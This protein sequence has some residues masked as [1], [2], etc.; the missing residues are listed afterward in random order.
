MSCG[1]GNDVTSSGASAVSAAAPASNASPAITQSTPATTATEPKVNGQI[2][3]RTGVAPV[4][5]QMTFVNPELLEI[6]N[7]SATF[8]GTGP[9]LNI[10]S[11]P[12]FG[13]CYALMPYIAFGNPWTVYS[14][15]G[16]VSS[17]TYGEPTPH[18]KSASERYS[19]QKLSST[20]KATCDR[21]RMQSTLSESAWNNCIALGGVPAGPFCMSYDEFKSY[22]GS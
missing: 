9:L 16:C 19:F 14:N 21:A 7:A 4:V 11:N 18:Q 15:G 12:T 1:G 22:E 6:C 2:D 8:G 13:E 3:E 17:K 20:Q 5:A 10:K